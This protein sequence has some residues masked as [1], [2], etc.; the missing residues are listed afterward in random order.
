MFIS[1]ITFSCRQRSRPRHPL[2]SHSLPFAWSLRPRWIQWGLH[3]HLMLLDTLCLWV[4]PSGLCTFVMPV[5]LMISKNSELYLQEHTRTAGHHGRF[6]RLQVCEK[7]T[8]PSWGWQK[9]PTA[10]MGYQNSFQ[11]HRCSEHVIP[12]FNPEWAQLLWERWAHYECLCT[13]FVT[14][15]FA[16]PELSP[17]SSDS[18]VK[19]LYFIAYALHCTSCTPLR[20][21]CPHP[22]P[23]TEGAFLTMGS[24]GYPFV[25]LAALV[26]L[27]WLKVH[28][29][30]VQG[31]SGYPSMTFVA[32]ILL[33]RLKVHVPTAQGSSGHWLSPGLFQY[34]WTL[35]HIPL[36]SSCQW[37]SQP[38]HPLWSHS[39]HLKHNIYILM[40]SVTDQ[41][42]PNSKS[43]S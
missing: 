42:I 6:M 22:P 20:S 28:F 30:T 3:F 37:R 41:P 38:H 19:L 2:G 9:F 13:K 31:S 21:L 39:P 25:T 4:F 26:L 11:M 15:L 18:M 10:L 43:Y 7:M 17:S 34:S 40:P 12:M 33:Q 29:L 8:K 5:K 14:S 16:C 27:Q 1:N 23:M 32:L 24:S 36:T 35:A